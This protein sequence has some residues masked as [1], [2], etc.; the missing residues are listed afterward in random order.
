M[1]S[2]ARRH[3]YR[4]CLVVAVCKEGVQIVKGFPGGWSWPAYDKAFALY[5]LKSQ[6][7]AQRSRRTY[8]V[9]H[10]P[11]SQIDRPW[12]PQVAAVQHLWQASSELL[13]FPAM[14]KPAQ[15]SSL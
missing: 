1:L 2:L 11:N 7:D 10:Q 4:L 9:T 5:N 13:V 12:K 3:T 15:Q 6:T 8:R 14:P